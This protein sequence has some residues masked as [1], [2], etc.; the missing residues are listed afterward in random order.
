MNG[1]TERK[2]QRE[3][4]LD[5]KRVRGKEER[6]RQT[7]ENNC[8]HV[9]TKA[10]DFLLGTFTAPRGSARHTN[11]CHRICQITRYIL[12]VCKFLCSCADFCVRACVLTRMRMNTKLY[13]LVCVNKK[14]EKSN[15]PR[16]NMRGIG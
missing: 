11:K 13:S 16:R 2:R 12:C 15:D 14:S 8:S 9:F 1:E 5:G 4:F 7:W 6:A 3:N 10:Q